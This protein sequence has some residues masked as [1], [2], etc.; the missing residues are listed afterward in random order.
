MALRI[1]ASSTAH[2]RL[3]GRV[4]RGALVAAAAGLLLVACGDDG[5]VDDDAAV[6]TE[7]ADGGEEAAEPE[8][9]DEPEADAADDPDE[10]PSSGGRF[11]MALSGDPGMLNPAITTA[12]PV[13]Q[14][15]HLL[16]DGLVDRTDDGELLPQLAESW[17]VED[18]GARYRFRLRDDVVWHDGEPFT[19]E[20]VRYT[21]E[22]VLLEFHGRTRASVGSALDRL[23]VVDDHTIEFHFREPYGPL[24][25]QL[26]VAEGPILPS[27]LFA[28][29]DPNDNPANR[30]PVGTG[31]FRFVSW[32]DDAEL[33]YE[34]NPDYF[35]ADRPLLDEVV[36]RI[37]PDAASQVL[38]LQAGEIDLVTS[39][40][41]PDLEAVRADEQLE[42]ISTFRGAGGS[43]CSMTWAFNLEDDLLGQQEVRTALAQAVDRDAFVTSVL[44]GAGRA[45]DAPLHGALAWAQGD[46]RFPELDREA[47]AAALDD[48]GW[49]ED[50][51]GSRVATGVEG[52]EDGTPLTIDVAH[53]PQF[54]PY[55]DLLRSQL[56]ELGVEL[57][58]RPLEPPVL[59]ETVFTERD[60]D[61]A[62]I[63]YCQGPDPEIGARR[64]ID[65]AQ[66]G[67]VPFSNAAAYRNEE[68]DRLL[69]EAVREVDL[70]ARGALYAELQEIL[71]EELP[72]LMLVEG[73][74]VLAHTADCQGVRASNH[75]ALD[76]T[77][78][79]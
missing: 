16:Y 15:A 54:G 38:A 57:E 70:E 9:A 76:V 43:N 3:P 12:G 7:D 67:P 42:T 47:A 49:T 72:Y 77:C 69:A 31:P 66:I 11:V 63:S 79:R 20:D 35:L 73:E 19:A 52:V 36:L 78:T 13:H 30:E 55:T 10:Q 50:G 34:R 8:E 18:D 28:G 37:I 26:D 5:A 61:T 53:F 27:H 62:L 17:E 56:L 68:V 74:G 4:L 22:E 33:V 48:L 24:L 25:Q 2:P 44:F 1:A 59:V 32:Q 14:A 71:V 64:M 75:I 45:A 46:A 6:D 23:E 29:T 51:D 60:F 58:S 21:Y 41:G 65:S 39:V 40:P